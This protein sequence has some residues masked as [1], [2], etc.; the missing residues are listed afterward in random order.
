LAVCLLSVVTDAART[1]RIDSREQATKSQDYTHLGS[2][3][4]A[5][6][7]EDDALAVL[8]ALLRDGSRARISSSG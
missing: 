4:R 5:Q 7:S 8:G 3:A 2:R 1:D 6:A